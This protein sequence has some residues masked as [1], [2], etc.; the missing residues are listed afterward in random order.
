M[1]DSKPMRPALRY[2]IAVLATASAVALVGTLEPA[3]GFVP[4]LL[5]AVVAAVERY[6]GVGPA[7][8]A[9]VFCTL[10]SL[11]FVGSHPFADVRIRDIAQL[12]LFPPVSA[13]LL[14]LMES[15]RQQRRVVRE[16][17]LELSTLLDSMQEA[18][19]IFSAD[20]RVVDANRA[21]E[22]LCGCFRGALLG[23]YYSE[24]AM[25]LDIKQDDQPLVP[26]EMSVARALRGV[27][28]R[29]EPRTILDPVD[30]QPRNLMVSASP[31]RGDDGA[32]IGALLVIRDL[33]ELMQLQRHI[34]DTER[35]VAIGQMA[36]GIAHDFNNV[37]NT[38][39]QAVAVLQMG[40]TRP[41]EERE[42]Y[43]GMI[44]RAARTGAEIIKRIR[45]YIRGGS[46]DLAPVDASH[47]LQQAVELTEPLWRKHPE[48]HVISDLRPVG[49]VRANAA[50][51]Q[52]VFANLIINAIQA[53][54]QGG[55]LRVESERSDDQV[56]I[57][58][59]DTGIGILP[60]DHKRIFMPYYTTKP[61]GTGLGLSTAQRTVLAQG[62][63][64]SFSSQQGHGTTFLV[65]LPSL[66]TVEPQPEKV[67]A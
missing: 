13:S 35:H 8:F 28:V 30:R 41:A 2:L 60:G 26:A 62:G 3:I 38:I 52:R 11:F 55:T 66:G 45:E 17:L 46:G 43:L 37:L 9:T 19:A 67:A 36:S 56:Q 57:R 20:G 10:G 4:L 14:Y 59:C 22:Q 23:R 47:L 48:I 32:I 24:L 25:A 53:M 42:R 29:E 65:T 51:L 18:V 63:N 50:D 16:Q 40:P 15:R 49:L 39:T 5:L 21:A 27:T 12:S 61:Q 33:T 7:V 34:A 44:D 64:I 31:M 58:V 54:P 1:L 6:A